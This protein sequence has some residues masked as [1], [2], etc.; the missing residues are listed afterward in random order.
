MY[1]LSLGSPYFANN[2]ESIHFTSKWECPS[3]CVMDGS[4]RDLP[5]GLSQVIGQFVMYVLNMCC[6][7]MQCKGV[8][9]GGGFTARGGGALPLTH[10]SSCRHPGSSPRSGDT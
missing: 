5:S 3:W 10:L 4:A 7:S 6:I 2:S 9:D 8:L 1:S